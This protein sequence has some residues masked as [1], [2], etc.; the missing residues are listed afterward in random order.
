MG[1]KKTR[2]RTGGLP[3]ANCK[4]LSGPLAFSFFTLVILSMLTRLVALFLLFTTRAPTLL[5]L[6]LARSIL[7]FV[8]LIALILIVC[9]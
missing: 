8:A 9:H 4:P 7:A 1:A 5:F 6:P 3:G 2:R